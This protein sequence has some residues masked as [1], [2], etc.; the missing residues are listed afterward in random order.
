VPP[1]AELA[2]GA[3]AARAI[4]EK[5]L[6]ASALIVAAA[7][8]GAVALAWWRLIG[9][10]RAAGAM[11]PMGAGNV[12]TAA[13]LGA[14]FVMWALMMVAMMLPSASP[15]ILLYERFVRRSGTG[16]ALGKTAAF[17]LAYVAVWAAFS[18]AA[19]IGQAALISSGIV[20]EMA[21]RIGN[22]RIAGALLL[23]AGLYQMSS[24]KQACLESCRSPLSFLMRSWR[25]GIAG[26]LRLGLAHGTYCLGCCWALMLLLFVGGVMSLGWVAALAVLVFVEKLAP[27]SLRTSKVIATG[28][29]GAGTLLALG[30]SDWGS[31]LG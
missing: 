20:S 5:R 8:A 21:L 2:G 4:V 18:A 29:L 31:F 14:A 23:L 17:T 7:V 13:Y 10:G 22:G 30:V 19:V 3:E 15:M 26:A 25:P 28:L 1:E 6:T 24:V 16:N 9:T 27:V 12:W 11:P